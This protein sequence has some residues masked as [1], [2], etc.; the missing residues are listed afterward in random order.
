MSPVRWSRALCAA[1]AVFMV[2]ALGGTPAAAAGDE[3]RLTALSWERS[4]V[5][6][7]GSNTLT[8]TVKYGFGHK[9]TF[10][11]ATEPASPLP[12]RQITF[13]QGFSGSATAASWIST[14]GDESTYRYDFTVPRFATSA[15][16]VWAVGRFTITG[17]GQS[18]SL[19]TEQVRSAFPATFVADT[20]A[21]TVPPTYGAVKPDPDF[22]S[23]TAYV[24][25]Q[26]GSLRY[27]VPVSDDRTAV[28]S[29]TVTVSGPNA[30]TRTASRLITDHDKYVVEV[31]MPPGSPAGVWSVSRIEAVDQAGNVGRYEGLALA[32]IT[33]TD[34]AIVG[35]EPQVIGSPVNPFGPDQT[36]E[37]VIPMAPTS[38]AT[39]AKIDIFEG[40]VAEN[41]ILPSEAGAPVRIRINAAKMSIACTTRALT[42]ADAAGAVA[43]FGPWYQG[44]PAL[45]SVIEGE[46][47]YAKIANVALRGDTVD[48][49]RG[50]TLTADFDIVAES[51]PPVTAARLDVWSAAWPTS[52][53]VTSG[54]IAPVGGKASLSVRFPPKLP[55]A[56]YKVTVTLRD[57]HHSR[58]IQYELGPDGTVRHAKVVL[59]PGLGAFTATDPT[60]LLDTRSAGGPVG[61]RE[62][63]TLA[64]SGVPADATAVVLNVTAAE[65]T[66]A[67]FLT[68]WPDGAPRPATSNL[69]FQAGQTVPNLVTVPVVNGKVDFYNHVGRVHVIA[70]LFGFYAPTS[71]AVFFPR[72]PQRVLDT[73][74]A[75]KK[76]DTHAA[77]WVTIPDITDGH[78]GTTAAVLNVTVTEPDRDSYLAVG[79]WATSNLNFRAGQTV[80]NQV[81][82]K[83]DDRGTFFFTTPARAHVVIDV[84]GYYVAPRRADGG[85]VFAPTGPAR[86]MD[87]RDGTGVRAGSLG[88]GEEVTLP[89]AG[90]A[91]VPATATAVTLNV[92]ATEPTASSFL[93]VWPSGAARPLA[94]S[95]NFTAGATVPNLVTVP[96]V[97]GKVRFYNHGGRVHVIADVFG[98]FVG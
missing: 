31:P 39:S 40:C 28:H 65:S 3:P 97:D 75:G 74:D 2:L 8:F 19:T 1:L 14:S 89:V 50:G 81:V 7:E 35:G 29:V 90:L 93:T 45:P 70:D 91:G 32:P 86:L 15:S 26:G 22:R 88:A 59:G 23:D 94:S 42:I 20:V 66:A 78:D 64:L 37:L 30:T 41:P 33:V 47:P 76:T 96:V 38:R 57:Q 5:G 79:G 43:V 11:L 95:L 72:T 36:V 6:V 58:P 16:T 13:T 48:W 63:R 9:G 12:P 52:V 4:K 34:N 51:A 60:R 17:S 54:D 69:N 49:L 21:D 18:T 61:E 67:S 25:P 84:L 71:K 98:Y 77:N 46:S 62:T 80:A 10:E 83:T 92:T 87:T 55:L 56:D 73:R 44:G 85:H 24:G 27:Q 68:V 53:E 82:V